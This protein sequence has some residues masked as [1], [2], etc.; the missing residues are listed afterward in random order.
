MWLSSDCRMSRLGEIAAA[1]IEL[2]PDSGLQQKKI[3]RHVL[4][5]CFLRYK[6][7]RKIFFADVPT[8]SYRQDRE[9]EIK[10]NLSERKSGGC[11]EPG[12]IRKI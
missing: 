3:L 2:K 8:E 12:L 10:K 11:P 1:I 4:S 9:A 5:G 7:P 6:R